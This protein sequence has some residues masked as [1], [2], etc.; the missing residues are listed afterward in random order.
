MY[1]IQFVEVKWFEVGYVVWFLGM[2]GWVMWK[3]IQ[4]WLCCSGVMM[5]L[6]LVVVLVFSVDMVVFL[7]LMCELVVG[8]LLVEWIVCWWCWI[9]SL[10]GVFYFDLDG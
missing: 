3:G 8:V 2:M 9:D 6:L 1:S 7:L 10:G 5:V 4:G